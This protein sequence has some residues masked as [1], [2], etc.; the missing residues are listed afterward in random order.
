MR[1]DMF[2]SLEWLSGPPWLIPFF[3]GETLTFVCVCV[4]K[5]WWGGWLVCVPP[6]IGSLTLHILSEETFA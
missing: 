4:C 2:A 5:G 6:L 3:T 1:G